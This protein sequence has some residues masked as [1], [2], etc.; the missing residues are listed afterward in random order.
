MVYLK[1]HTRKAMIATTT[2]RATTTPPMT[3]PLLPPLLAA[4]LPGD[5]GFPVVGE[6]VE[7]VGIVAVLLCGCWVVC[8][9][10]LGWALTNLPPSKLLMFAASCSTIFLRL[11]VDTTAA[12]PSA[13]IFKT[14]S[15]T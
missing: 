8:A 1:Y 2:T 11:S 13:K 15:S 6:R 3:L 7:V 5:A 12:V 9:G 4:T 14:A 10:T